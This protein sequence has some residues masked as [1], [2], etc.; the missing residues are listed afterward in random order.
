MRKIQI[1]KRPGWYVVYVDG[2]W[3][4]AYATQTAAAQ[5][6]AGIR[7]GAIKIAW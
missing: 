3:A 6:A 5:Y 1:I 2:I 7:S 4:D